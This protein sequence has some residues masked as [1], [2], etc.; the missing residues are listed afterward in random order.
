MRQPITRPETA[1]HARIR[2]IAWAGV[3]VLTT[4]LVSLPAPAKDF[5][6]DYAPFQANYGGTGLLETPNARMAPV[7]EFAFTYSNADPY[8]NFAFS[9]QPF[10][11][12]QG[13]F[14]YTSISERDFGAGSDRDYL[15]K[16]VDVKLKLLGESRLIPQVALGFRDFGGT[17]LFGSEFL[18]ANKRWYDFDVSFGIAWGYLGA[19][20]DIKN[21]LTYIDDGF[22]GRDRDRSAGG[23]DFNFKSLFTGRSAFFGGIEYHTPFEPLTLQVEYEGNDYSR[24]PLGLDIEQDLPVNFGARL[25]VNDNLALTGAFERGNTAM[26]GA[27]L[28]LGLAKLYQPKSDPPPAPIT[29]APEQTT[30]DWQKTAQALG[31][32]AGIQVRRIKTRGDTVIIEGAQSRY[33]DLAQGELRANRILNSVSASNISSFQ[34]RYANRGFYLRRDNLARDPMPDAAPFFT[35]PG[36]VF[37]SDD[38]RYDV[39]VVD[40]SSNEIADQATLEKTVYEQ[41][42]DRFSWNIR[43]ALVQNFGGPDGYLFQVLVQASAE[44]RTDNNGWFSGTLGYSVFDNFDDFTY[45]ADSDLPRVRTFVNRYTDE[46]DLGVFNLQYTRT[47]RLS[48]NWFGMGYAGLLEQMFGGVGGEVLYRPF[49]SRAAFGLDLNYVRQ[50][51]FDTQFD[52][53]DYDAV[54]GH[55]TAYVDTGFKDILVRASVGQYL[56][57]DYGGTLDISREFDSGVRLGAYATYTDASYNDNFGEGGFDKGIYI[58]IPL[59]TFFTR[60]TRN[61]LPLTWSPLTRD[62]GAFLNRRYSLYGLTN[63]RDVDDYWRGFEPPESRR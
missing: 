46:T 52:F 8:S 50:R 24:E 63:D 18:V 1:R 17:G 14:R 56:A 48:D 28:S 32:N 6:G 27:T 26:F 38:Y 20:G 53:R 11:W 47:A 21:P 10:S 13:G 59:D 7:G 41:N 31:E 4:P 12:L 54:T 23:G 25:R 15:D 2:S 51:S 55:A 34:Y 3:V 33:R 9:F 44:L 19:R 57:E 60:S 49:N 58:T 61:T 16:G 29:A 40:V 5:T 35:E 37:A 45:V 62:G 43:P 42:P 22:E 30:D 39:K 36:S